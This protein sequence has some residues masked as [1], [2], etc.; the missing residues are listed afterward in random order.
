MSIELLET[1]HEYRLGHAGSVLVVIWLTEPTVAAIR[2]LTAHHLALASVHGKVTL[3][4]VIQKAAGN[5]APEVREAIREQS[6][7]VREVRLGSV[8]VVQMKGIGAVFVRS[9]LALMSIVSTEPLRSAKTLDDAANEIRGLQ[10]QD[11]AT[12]AN[13]TLA[14][15][16]SDFVNRPQA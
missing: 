8:V 6:A 9:Y 12:R 11:A 3:L 7:A 1:R 14:E 2:A 10:G 16:L 15:A 4:S 5:P 13:A